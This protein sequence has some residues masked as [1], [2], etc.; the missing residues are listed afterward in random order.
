MPMPTA[1]GVVGGII[2]IV[3]Q[4][5]ESQQIVVLP[6]GLQ[7]HILEDV[8]FQIFPDQLAGLGGG[9]TPVGVDGGEKGVC[10]RPWEGFRRFYVL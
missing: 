2:K 6:R 10:F 7:D 8:D 1:G 3:M 5:K 4:T 9:G